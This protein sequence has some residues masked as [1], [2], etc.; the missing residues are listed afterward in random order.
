MNRWLVAAAVLSAAACLVHLFVG[1]TA[2]YQPAL[3]LLGEVDGAIFSAVWHGVSLI[4][5]INTVA[6][7]MAARPHALAGFAL[8][9][10]AIALS[11]AV[12]FLGFGLVRLGSLTATPQWTIFL[13]IGVLGLIGWRR[14]A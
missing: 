14:H 12:T 5:A 6:F 11:L 9:P 3:A 7:F 4:L 8:Q 13:L 2:F 10:T 1:G